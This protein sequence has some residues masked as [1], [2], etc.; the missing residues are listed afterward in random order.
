M[1]IWRMSWIEA[2]QSC[3]DGRS[4]VGLSELRTTWLGMAH[5]FY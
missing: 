2:C 4:V 5:L 3:G 1:K